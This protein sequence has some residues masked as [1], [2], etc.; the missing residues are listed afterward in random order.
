MF[1]AIGSEN[2]APR[3]SGEPYHIFRSTKDGGDRIFYEEEDPT[4]H[5]DFEAALAKAGVPCNM[6][7]IH[8]FCTQK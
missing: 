6:G 1:L 8:P 3:P 2:D 4:V 5:R 7:Q